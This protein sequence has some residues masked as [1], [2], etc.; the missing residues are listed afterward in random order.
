MLLLML[1]KQNLNMLGTEI[2]FTQHADCNH[3]IFAK[4]ARL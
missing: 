4:R 2:C 1:S 3:F